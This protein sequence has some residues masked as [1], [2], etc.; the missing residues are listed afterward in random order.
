MFAKLE[1]AVPATANIYQIIINICTRLKD[2]IFKYVF[3]EYIYLL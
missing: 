3:T 2:V 1:A